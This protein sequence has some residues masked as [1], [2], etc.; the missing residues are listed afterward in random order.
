MEETAPTDPK[1]MIQRNKTVTHSLEAQD[2]SKCVDIFQRSDST[3]GFEEFRRD[4]EDTSGWFP[5]GRYSN[6]VFS[7]AEAALEK[8]KDLVPW[9]SKKETIYH[10]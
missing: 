4:I 7:S 6:I 3:F 1:I 8:A 10:P 2:H 9:I 5:T